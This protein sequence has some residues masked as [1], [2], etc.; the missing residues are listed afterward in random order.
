MAARAG[1]ARTT[2]RN[3][4]AASIA[5][6]WIVPGPGHRLVLAPAFVDEAMH[7]FGL[8]FIWMHTLATAAWHRLRP[9]WQT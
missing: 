3:F 4:I 8:E 7:G 9:G 2:A 1:V 5:S 6:G